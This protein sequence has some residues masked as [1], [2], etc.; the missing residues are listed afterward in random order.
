MMGSHQGVATCTTHLPH[1]KVTQIPR[2]KKVSLCIL[3][4]QSFRD[5]TP[6]I[7]S[8]QS[9][10][11]LTWGHNSS[12]FKSSLYWFTFKSLEPHFFLFHFFF[13]MKYLGHITSFYFAPINLLLFCICLTIFFLRCYY[14]YIEIRIKVSFAFYLFIY[15]L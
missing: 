2:T 4:K 7:L 14:L 11:I 3:L 10:H 8:L 6:K 9:S 13:I 12:V 15:N 1:H 5:Q